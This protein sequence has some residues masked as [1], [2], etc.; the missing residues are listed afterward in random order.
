MLTWTI[1]KDNCSF[2]IT[3]NDLRQL[4]SGNFLTYEHFMSRPIPFIVMSIFFITSY[5]TLQQENV[6][7]EIV[8]G[9]QLTR[10]DDN[11]INIF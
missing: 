9:S 7:I 10:K 1:I 3:V 6:S 4:E 8:L 11:V 5:F 2:L